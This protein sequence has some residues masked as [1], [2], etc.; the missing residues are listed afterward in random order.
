MDKTFYEELNQRQGHHFT[1]AKAAQWNR[2]PDKLLGN[3]QE[4]HV[5]KNETRVL[6]FNQV[7]MQKEFLSEA[8]C[9]STTNL[10]TGDR[11]STELSESFML[12][13][14]YLEF[15]ISKMNL[16]TEEGFIVSKHLKFD[17]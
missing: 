13:L 12:I 3:I 5:F 17:Y 9:S 14:F 6:E 2:I 15:Y 7:I 4:C 8:I 10:R 16:E 1:A 11:N